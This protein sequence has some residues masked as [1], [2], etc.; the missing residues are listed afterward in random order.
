[1]K[2]SLGSCSACLKSVGSTGVSAGG[3][4]YHRDC[5]KCQGCRAVLTLKFYIN[6]SQP[7]CESC[8]KVGLRVDLLAVKML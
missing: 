1:M 2:D 3:R 6:Q 4:T 8:Y 5:F 7:F